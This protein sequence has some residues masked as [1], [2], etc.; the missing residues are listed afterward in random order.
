MSDKQLQSSASTRDVVD[1]DTGD[2][3]FHISRHHTVPTQSHPHYFPAKVYSGPSLV[4]A[5][6]QSVPVTSQLPDDPKAHVDFTVGG[7]P[8]YNVTRS[9]SH[10]ISTVKQ[11]NR[12][13][14][15]DPRTS[16]P[17]QLQHRRYTTPG[18][19]LKSVDR[20]KLYSVKDNALIGE[21]FNW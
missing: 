7:P 18:G 9:T 5:N 21:V 6:V 12:L 4:A 17:V 13:S 16:L 1:Y 14:Y 10:P 8:V 20:E 2:D 19:D 11:R 15:E 3:E